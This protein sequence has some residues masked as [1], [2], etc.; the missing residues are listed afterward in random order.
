MRSATL[1][2]P[3]R[4]PASLRQQNLLKAGTYQSL[5]AIPYSGPM[6]NIHQVAPKPVL[7]RLR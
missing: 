5:F 3:T 6:S 4:M 2:C 7:M 1:I